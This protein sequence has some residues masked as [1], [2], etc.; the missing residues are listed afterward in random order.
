MFGDR[1]SAALFFTKS[2]EVDSPTNQFKFFKPSKKAVYMDINFHETVKFCVLV[3]YRNSKLFS[4]SCVCV[5][6]AGSISRAKSPSL[7]M[8][9]W[10][11]PL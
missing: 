5:C 9:L 11:S 8:G 1:Y 4:L 10:V 7:C 6:V 2:Q 3:K